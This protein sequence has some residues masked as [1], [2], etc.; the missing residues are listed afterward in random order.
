MAGFGGFGGMFRR[1]F[2]GGR[3]DMNGMFSGPG[4]PG[5]GLISGLPDP[6]R[7]MQM[8]YP[9]EGGQSRG[10]NWG[11]ILQMGGGFAGGVANWLGGKA[12][13]DLLKDQFDRQQGFKEQQYADQQARRLQMDAEFEE[14]ERIR[15]L[16]GQQG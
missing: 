12:D 3:G 10:R 7:G 9:Q 5:G 14:R 6:R 13:R 2:G 16:R 1:G 15:R 8:P 11:D 4:I